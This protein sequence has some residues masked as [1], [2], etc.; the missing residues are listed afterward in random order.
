MYMSVRADFFVHAHIS[1]SSWSKYAWAICFRY[2]ERSFRRDS[3]SVSLSNFS[4]IVSQKQWNQN[5]VEKKKY[6]EVDAKQNKW[7]WS[8]LYESTLG[9]WY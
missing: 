7:K 1:L 2:T 3:I 8:Y 5:A 9:F 4:Y 6:G